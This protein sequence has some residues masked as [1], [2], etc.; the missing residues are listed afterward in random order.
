[1]MNL[2]NEVPKLKASVCCF[3]TKQC[4]TRTEQWQLN[5]TQIYQ[6]HSHDLWKHFPYKPAAIVS[7]TF[8]EVLLLDSDAYVTRDPEGLFSD[9]MYLEFGALFYADAYRS[10]QNP[11]L[12]KLLNTSCAID[13]YELDSATILVNKKRVWNG[14]YLT[15]LINDEHTLFYRV[16]VHRNIHEERSFLTL[17]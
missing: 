1:M 17:L 11:L 5:A 14:I 15:K 6:P 3:H 16:R 13:E 10:R 8:T 7:A 4:R 12:W 9:P 2:I